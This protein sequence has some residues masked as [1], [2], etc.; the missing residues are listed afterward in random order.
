MECCRF[1]LFDQGPNLFP[2]FNFACLFLFSGVQALDIRMD[3]SSFSFLVHGRNFLPVIRQECLFLAASVH[4]PFLWR[5]PRLANRSFILCSLVRC[6]FIFPSFKVE[7]RHR[8]LVTVNPALIA[9]RLSVGIFSS[10]YS[11]RYHA[12]CV[13]VVWSAPFTLSKR[14]ICR[15]LSRPSSSEAWFGISILKRSPS[16]AKF[17]MRITPHMVK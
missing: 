6:R 11:F 8:Y 14:A 5:L 10:H 7:L 9:Y 3:C 15:P 16:L 1:L 12:N 2:L 4:L 13:F 17:I